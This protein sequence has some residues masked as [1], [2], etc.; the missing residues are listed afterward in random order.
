MFF[1]LYSARNGTCFS[2]EVP[3]SR[4]VSLDELAL[5]TPGYVG[6]DLKALVREAAMFAVNRLTNVN[7]FEPFFEQFFFK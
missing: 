4:D 5:L 6:A 3:L 2:R 1:V 7:F